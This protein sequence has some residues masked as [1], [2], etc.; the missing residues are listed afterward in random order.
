MAVI[1]SIDTATHVCSVAIHSNSECLGFLE[2]TLENAHAKQLMLSIEELLKS[3]HLKSKD[4]D[5]VAVSIGPGSYTGL[6][7]GV[8]VAK[9]LAYAL[10]IPILAID[11]L[12]ALAHQALP[13]VEKDSAFVIPM[14]DARRMEVY[15]ALINA[16]MK[17]V[18][19]ARPVI[20]DEFSYQ[21]ELKRGKVH[22]LGDGSGKLQEVLNHP[23]ARFHSER[24]SAITVGEL[25]A[26]KYAER[27]FADLAYL[28]PNYL[29]EFRVLAS[30]KNPL[31]L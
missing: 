4:L 11:T 23:N 24:N 22:F 26:K 12:H 15:A 31:L 16:Q 28:E 2:T 21:E 1:L 18:E 25:A 30:K 14:I 17:I 7:I 3:L 8:S 5:A 20:V 29:K 9:G 27:D 6:R 10:N 19:Q 13:Y